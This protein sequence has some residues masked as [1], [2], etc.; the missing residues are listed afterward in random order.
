[1]TKT[2]GTFVTKEIGK[3]FSRFLI[4][5]LCQYNYLLLFAYIHMWGGVS[6]QC[7]WR[8]ESADSRRLFYKNT[9]TYYTEQHIN[10]L[11]THT[12]II[13]DLKWDITT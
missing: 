13:I 9:H 1:L 11:Y 2:I 10:I 4:F 12:F 3:R 8:G 7:V 5:L 6:P